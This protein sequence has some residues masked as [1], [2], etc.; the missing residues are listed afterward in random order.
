MA[1]RKRTSPLEDLFD[2]FFELSGMFWQVGAVLSF[3]FF[4]GGFYTLMDA[5]NYVPPETSF[6]R[7]LFIQY[8]WLRYAVP[9]V[10]FLCGF[11]FG[12]KAASTYERQNY[13]W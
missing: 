8:A 4:G 7:V 10:L 9:T 11:I 2:L 13:R 12:M 5:I 6:L 1:R 3:V